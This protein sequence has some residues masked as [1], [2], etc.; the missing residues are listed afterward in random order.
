MAPLAHLVL[1]AA[2]EGPL[3]CRRGYR[4]SGRLEG[5]VGEH[6]L[7]ELL[8]GLLETGSGAPVIAVYLYGTW[9]LHFASHYI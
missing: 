8:L 2:L 1:V 7:G 9:T 4:G 6:T 3:S 5:L